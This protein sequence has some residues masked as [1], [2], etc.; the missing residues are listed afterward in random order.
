MTALQQIMRHEGF[1]SKPYVDTVGKLT[2]GYGRN[3][4]DTGISKKEANY[5]LRKDYQTAKADARSVFGNAFDVLNRPRQAVIVNMAFNLGLSRL[6][7]FK[8]MLRAIRR[9]NYVVAAVEMLDSR[10]AK[11]VGDRATELA[12]QMRTGRWGK[13]V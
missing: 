1:R 11:Q 3:L 4:G 2:I 10:W 7:R 5:L 13:A 9:G 8:R 12:K 6:K